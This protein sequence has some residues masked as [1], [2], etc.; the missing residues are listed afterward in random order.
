MQTEKERE[1]ETQ[2]QNLHDASEVPAFPVWK[3]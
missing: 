3:R 1:E 2:Y